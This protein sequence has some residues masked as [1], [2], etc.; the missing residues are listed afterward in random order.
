MDDGEYKLHFE[1]ANLEMQYSI[2]NTDNPE[3]SITYTIDSHSIHLIITE[4][5]LNTINENI[6]IFPNPV[7]SE[8][9]INMPEHYSGK[10]R[11]SICDMS[12]RILIDK[13]ILINRNISPKL[14]LKNLK[15]G[16]YILKIQNYDFIYETKLMKK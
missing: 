1:K 10:F 8:C 13:Q 9:S 4:N 5:N 6:N 3:E 14:N 11:I 15:S 16:I 7:I 2:H 12:G